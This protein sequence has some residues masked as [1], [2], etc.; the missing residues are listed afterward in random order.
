[1]IV[2]PATA[3]PASLTLPR[4]APLLSADAGNANAKETTAAHVAAK[5]GRMD[6]LVSSG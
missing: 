4:T 1:V 3:L 2:A 5:N 6:S